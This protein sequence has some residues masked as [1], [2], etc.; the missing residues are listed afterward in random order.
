MLGFLSLYLNSGFTL[1]CLF[2]HDL[3]VDLF[4]K[5]DAMALVNI[6]SDLYVVLVAMHEEK[7]WIG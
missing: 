5:N 4:C 7:S 6:S 1:W 3:W 2:L